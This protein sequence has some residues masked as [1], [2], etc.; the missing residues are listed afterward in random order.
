[1][2]M[3]LFSSPWRIS[4]DL[5]SILI[6]IALKIH[7]K[8]LNLPWEVVIKCKILDKMLVK[9][10]LIPSSSCRTSCSACRGRPA[11][12][13]P[14]LKHSRW[15]SPT[16]RAAV[17]RSFCC[18]YFRARQ[19]NLVHQ[20]NSLRPRRLRVSLIW[21]DSS[22]KTCK[23]RNLA[24]PPQKMTKPSVSS[25]FNNFWRPLLAQ[26]R[27]MTRTLGHLRS[28]QKWRILSLL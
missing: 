28:D 26:S 9:L 24:T 18:N 14:R 6:R 3:L 13:D 19:P 25:K 1:M 11:G 17:E 15:H 16:S 2:G 20:C 21:P 23:A 12:C 4:Q 10:H 5:K 22:K 27:P 8:P 7:C